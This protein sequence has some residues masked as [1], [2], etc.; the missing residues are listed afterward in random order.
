MSLAPAFSGLQ[1]GLQR[2]RSVH[3]ARHHASSDQLKR[4]GLMYQSC[5]FLRVYDE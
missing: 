3:Q 1:T 5:T 4:S 2:H